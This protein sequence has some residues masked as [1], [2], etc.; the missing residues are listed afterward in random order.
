MKKVLI[1]KLGHSET[2]NPE[3]SRTCSLGDVLRTTVI[4]NYLKDYHVSWLVDDSA[5]PL[6]QGNPYINQILP[7]NLE[8]YVQLRYE[9]FDWVINLEKTPGMCAL[10]EDTMAWNK[11]GFRFDSAT[12]KAEAYA[13]AENVLMISQSSDLKKNNGKYWQEYLAQL[14]RK[15]WKPEHKYYL[16]KRKVEEEYDVGLNFKVGKKW[17]NKAWGLSNWQALGRQL[18]TRG[19]KVSWQE[20]SQ[21]LEAYLDWIASCSC[22]ITS[23]SLGLHVAL[24]LGK[25]VIGLFGP[26]SWKEVY[27]YGLGTIIHPGPEIPCA[28]CFQPRC[29]KATKACMNSIK[30]HKVLEVYEELHSG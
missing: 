23:D 4:L 28:P 16:K 17:S 7:W 18:E 3:I 12:G 14:L 1:I 15:T 26:S 27:M 13:D 8:T 9:T 2:L 25:S 20:G 10:V 19:Q 29:S 30:V 5:I 22:L 21:N 24:A 6:L 11:S